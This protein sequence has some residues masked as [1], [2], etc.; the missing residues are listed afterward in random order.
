VLAAGRHGG[1]RGGLHRRPDGEAPVGVQPGGQPPA[2]RAHP[3]GQRPHR[4]G[5]LR[6]RHDAVAGHMQRQQAVALGGLDE[7]GPRLRLPDDVG[8]RLPEHGRHQGTRL[9]ERLAVPDPYRHVHIGRRQQP[10]RGRHLGGQRQAAQIGGGGPRGGQQAA[11]G[12]EHPGELVGPVRR[13]GDG[14]EPAPDALVQFGGHPEP[15]LLD[16]RHRQ[17]E[18]GREDL[19]DPVGHPAQAVGQQ[20]GQD[21][22]DGEVE[23]AGQRVGPDPGDHGHGTGHQQGRPPGRGQQ[24]RAGQ[25][26]EHP[27]GDPE[28][29][30]DDIGQR[31]LDHHRAPG[32]EPPETGDHVPQLKRE[33]RGRQG[34]DDGRRS[35]WTVGGRQHVHGDHARQHRHRDRPR[36]PRMQP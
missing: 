4:L 9:A 36:G 1:R 15:L 33:D 6:G 24:Q 10:A 34:D 17:R 25:E 27:G 8:D 5:A 11:G 28:R 3:L 14:V 29:Q 16:G 19:L 13:P 20:A 2:G 22:R 23:Q 35:R 26:P 18:P 31:G 32:L 21:P 30:H 7:A 12:A